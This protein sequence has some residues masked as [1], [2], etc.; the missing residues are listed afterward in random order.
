MSSVPGPEFPLWCAGSKVA[1]LC[2]VGP[3]AEGAGLNV[4]TMSY[5]GQLSFGLAGCRRLVPDVQDLAVLLDDA[6]GELVALALAARPA[7]G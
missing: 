2:P 7:A 4:T 3:V 1:E 5:L 6:M